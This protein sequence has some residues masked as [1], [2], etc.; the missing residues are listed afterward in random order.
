MPCRFASPAHPYSGAA[1]SS[2]HADTCPSR[3]EADASCVS[4]FHRCSCV[5]IFLAMGGV[6]SA[7]RLIKIGAHMRCWLRC[8]VC[9]TEFAA[10]NTDI[11]E[12]AI[13][14]FSPVLFAASIYSPVSAISREE[15][16]SRMDH[17]SFGNFPAR[18]MAIASASS[19]VSAA[20]SKIA[21]TVAG[22]YTSMVNVLTSQPPV[23]SGA[24]C[25]LSSRQRGRHG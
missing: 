24:S 5:S 15:T 8:I 16:K 2:C 21:L 17:C 10:A 22:L 6:V 3:G 25:L 19:L 12:Q 20:T 7:Y 11:A 18:I 1:M 13:H 4:L 9:I 14:H 23:P